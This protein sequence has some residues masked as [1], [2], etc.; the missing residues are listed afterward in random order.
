MVLNIT[1]SE[2][3]WLAHHL[4]HSNV[5]DARFLFDQFLRINI[6]NY[7]SRFDDCER[8]VVLLPHILTKAERYQIHRYSI[9]NKFS[10]Q[11]FENIDNQRVIEINLSKLYVQE[12]FED[13]VFLE[14]IEEPVVLSPIEEVLKNDKQ[15]IFDEL[16]K[17][18]EKNL[19]DE[20]KNFLNG[21]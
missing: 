8:T 19:A 4:I 14:P 13:Y 18:I 3:E 7:L 21:I 11:S 5:L 17:F 2:Q 20:F 15:I 9:H 16:I 6:V 1:I 12:L 10:A